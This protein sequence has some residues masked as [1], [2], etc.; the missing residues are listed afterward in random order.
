MQNKKVSKI[1]SIIL[2]VTL[3]FILSC[4]FIYIVKEA[5]H[6]CDGDN[7]LICLNIRQCEENIRIKTGGAI[8]LFQLTAVMTAL[9]FLPIFT[10]NDIPKKT[11]IIQKVRLND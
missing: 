4:S 1:L 7:C 3:I 8:N 6:D 2:S 5:N 11:L 9:L 10:E